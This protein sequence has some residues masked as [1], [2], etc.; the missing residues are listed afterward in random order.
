MKHRPE[1]LATP[2]TPQNNQCW[3]GCETEAAVTWGLP[4]RCPV[5]VLFH[6]CAHIWRSQSALQQ[7]RSHLQFASCDTESQERGRSWFTVAWE[8]LS[9]GLPLAFPHWDVSS[10]K[11]MIR[12]C[13][14]CCLDITIPLNM[15]ENVLVALWLFPEEV[16]T[17]SSGVDCVDIPYLRRILK[18][19][20]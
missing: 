19:L 7:A 18:L 15:T 20:C 10:A 3:P 16:S 14:S 2:L 9:S 17:I 5:L 11:H 6:V 12:V 8:M 13:L 4:S 1:V